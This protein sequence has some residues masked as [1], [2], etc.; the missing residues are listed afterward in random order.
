MSN[1]GTGTMGEQ[2]NEKQALVPRL[3][4]PEFRDAGKWEKKTLVDVCLRITN[5]KANAEDH[6][7]DGIYPLYDRSEII[8]K[9]SEFA[10]DDEAVIIPGEGMRFQPK[11]H[12]GKF[13]LHQRAYALMQHQGDARFVYYA[14]D[15]FKD[16]LAKN[17]VKSTVLSLRLPIIEGFGLAVPRRVEQQ[18]I[19]DCLSSLDDLITAEIQKLDTLKTYKKGLMEQL[20]PREGE[21]AP[22]LRFPEFRDV[23]EW[24]KVAL[25]DVCERIMDGTHFSPTSKSG[26]Y[27]YLTSKNVRLGA[28]VL[29]DV[30]YISEEEHRSI[31]AR[32]PVKKNDLLLTKDGA[33][34][35]NCTLNPLDFEFSL[36]SSVAVIRGNPEKI[37]QKFLAQDFQSRHVQDQISDATSGQAITRITLEKIKRFKVWFTSF[38]EQQKIAD[39]LSSLD[40]LITAQ[41]QK[42][43]AFKFHKKG[44]MQQL[45]PVLDEVQA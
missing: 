27:L 22:R 29:D 45:F 9:S 11:Y 13:N 2:N 32:C 12:Q 42:I 8:K 6:E 35:G 34:T 38:H 5:G 33:S 36:L 44:L 14:L 37:L 31:F 15:R 17:A 18:K 23:G 41:S 26:P 7:D 24:E 4:F 1:K 20:F 10:F 28:L 16:T 19:A 3:R 43:D 39:C 40:E 21:T 30:S 25:G